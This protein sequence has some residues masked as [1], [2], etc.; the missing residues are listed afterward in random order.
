[1]PR[2]PLSIRLGLLVC[3]GVDL[4]NDNADNKIVYTLNYLA[5]G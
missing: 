4:L 1:M 2:V 5:A 3:F